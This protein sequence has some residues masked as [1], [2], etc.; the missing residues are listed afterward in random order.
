VTSSVRSFWAPGRVNLIGEHTD[1]SD[2]LVLPA[3]IDLGVVVSGVAADTIVLR[4]DFA[5]GRVEVAADGSSMRPTEGWTRYVAAVAHELD[6]CGRPPVGFAGAISSTLPSGAGL[7]SSA[8][9]EV[10]VAVALCSAADWH[11]LSP[12]ELAAACRRAEQ[13]AVGVPCGI[14]DQAVAVLGREGCAVLLDCGTL[15]F[16][17]VALP[18][19]LALVVIDSGVSHN[20]QHSGYAERRRELEEALVVLD[21]R[22]PADVGLDEAERLADARGLDDLH[23]RRL[24]HVVSE[25]ERVRAAARV[26]RAPGPVDRA[27]LGTIFLEGHASQRDDYETSTPELDLLVELAYEYGAAAARMTGGGFGGS[28]VALVASG[29]AEDF[30]ETVSERYRLRFEREP[31]V[32]ICAA[33]DGARE[34]S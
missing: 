5:G 29:H 25:N 2:G 33:A 32:R 10:A 28:V 31:A 15:E 1:Y 13:R 23:R 11:E 17:T 12:L 19:G 7:S 30:G 34:L 26:L 3:A 6:R 16:E 18:G 27:A 22:R 4:S 24:R 8:A 20:H 14:M 21:G 9:L